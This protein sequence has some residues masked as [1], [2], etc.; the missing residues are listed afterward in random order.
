MTSTPCM[1]LNRERDEAGETGHDVLIPPFQGR[2]A[3]EVRCRDDVGLVEH[4]L[5]PVIKKKK[6]HTREK[7]GVMRGGFP[8]GHQQRTLLNNLGGMLRPYLEFYDRLFFFFKSSGWNAFQLYNLRNISEFKN[9]PWASYYLCWTMILLAISL[10]K[11]DYDYYSW[12]S[13]YYWECYC[14]KLAV[15]RCSAET[16]IVRCIFPTVDHLFS[17]HKQQPLSVPAAREHVAGGG[18]CLGLEDGVDGP[19]RRD[20]VVA[21]AAVDDSGLRARL[22]KKYTRWKTD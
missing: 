14:P 11:L 22:R 3:A 8:I 4:V 20:V 15:V 16:S 12:S 17:Q 6:K 5:I 19:E 21:V 2:L 10:I 13:G 9:L 1:Y 18:G 7:R